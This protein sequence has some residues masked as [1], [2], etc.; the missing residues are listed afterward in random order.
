MEPLNGW[1]LIPEDEA[2][3]KGRRLATME[4][5]ATKRGLDPSAGV[6]FERTRRAWVLSTTKGS[7]EL[8]ADTWGPRTYDRDQAL[9]EAWR[10]AVGRPGVPEVDAIRDR[11][12]TLMQPSPTS[13][14]TANPD[15][16]QLAM[17]GR[18]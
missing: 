18:T 17:L 10:D 4:W 1:T 11:L 15:R 13:I 6:L 8:G 7:V 9:R 3:I 16:Q 12:N 2:M 14:S 5:L